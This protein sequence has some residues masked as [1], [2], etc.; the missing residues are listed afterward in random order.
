MNF[1]TLLTSLYWKRF[2][3]YFLVGLTILMLTFGT[4]QALIGGF[5]Q[6]GPTS[7]H[8]QEDDWWNPTDSNSGN[9]WYTG[10]DT[11]PQDN[12]WENTGSD[13]SQ[14]TQGPTTDWW[15]QTA[16]GDQPAGSTWDWQPPIDYQGADTGPQDNQW[17]NTASDFFQGEQ[18]P[19]TDWWNQTAG[20]EASDFFQ[21]QT[22]PTTDWW[23]QTADGGPQPGSGP[24]PGGSGPAGGDFDFPGRGSSQTSPVP[25]RPQAGP[26]PGS[27]PFPGQPSQPTQPSR[28][29]QAERAGSGPFPQ[30]QPINIDVRAEGGRASSSSNSSSSS[31]SSASV[32]NNIRN[33][34]RQE[35][36]INFPQPSPET[37]IREIPVVRETVREVPV[38]R[39]VTTQAQPRVVMAAGDT[40]VQEL[41]KTGLPFAG[42]LLG[43]LLPLGL[44]L[45]KFGRL[46]KDSFTANFIWEERQFALDR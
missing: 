1:R 27:G 5:L 26:Q 19:T 12:Q 13:F 22:E 40:K 3:N 15:N 8:A 16:D 35:Q 29:Q 9:N 25:P 38:E 37:V 42:A 28:P 2:K 20:D 32:T 23:N 14:S 24:F 33:S 4:Q 7:A 44:R 30:S 46:D 18:N 41:P 6:K 10:A 45:R 34:Q 36:T 43:G 39:V 17:E 11:G 31:R 21:G